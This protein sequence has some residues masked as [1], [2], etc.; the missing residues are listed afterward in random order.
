MD[1]QQQE[2]K[3]KTLAD[4]IIKRAKTKGAT[5]AEVSLNHG[6]G[7]STEV[8]MGEIDTLEYN[9]DQGLNMTVYFGQSKG[10]ASTADLSDKAIDE[11]IDAA[12]RIAKYTSADEYS[13]LAEPELIATDIEDLDLFHP[14]D[15]SAEQAIELT[16]ACEAEALQYDARI[17]NSDGAHFSSYAGMAIYANT[18]GFNAATAKSHHSL[19]CSVIA[20]AD[21]AMEREYDYDY[22]RLP[23]QLMSA[24]KIGLSVAEKVIKCL[25]AQ[26]ISTREAP[27]L[28]AANVARSL[29]GHFTGA[30][31]GG[32]LYRKASFLQDSIDQK[33]FPE[34]IHI[35]EQPYLAQAH[36][37]MAYDREGVATR[38]QDFV[39]Q[40]RVSRYIL[41]SYSARKLGMQ[42]TAN[43]GGT[44]NLTID[45]TG[46]SFDDLLKK[47]DTGLLV[48]NLMGSSVSLATGDYSR[49]AAGFW[50]E[51]GKIQFPVKEVTVAGNLKD[52]FQAMV[53]VGN[54][55][56][57][58]SATRTGSILLENMMIAGK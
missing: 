48:T 4:E 19:G 13:G 7:L 37:S 52:M 36:G 5:A 8:R 2:S 26:V 20:E 54:D 55:V 47:M 9:R 18:H 11:V 21:G 6:E 29:L 33:I 43:A 30:I 24:E 38:T 56:D 40:G 15:I 17:N 51:K 27:V 12:C 32:V 44:H 34:F 46:E 53:A 58:R 49:G 39:S 14:W 41:G 23:S 25:G 28:Y 50:V 1:I 57:H 42:T 10:S 22:S 16:K 35:H 45:S 31:S 3:L